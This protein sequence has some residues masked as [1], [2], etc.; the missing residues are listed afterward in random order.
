MN[1]ALTARQTQILKSI[2]DEYLETAEPVGSASLEKKYSLGISP[3]TI[4][5]EMANLTSMGYL[6]QPHTSAGRIPTSVAMKFYI[7][8][9]MEEKQMSLADEVKAKEEVWDV[10]GNLDRL[11]EEATKALASRTRNIAITTT[12]DGRVWTAGLANIFDNPEFEDDMNS[13][14]NIFS[15]IDNSPHV[16]ELFFEKMAG[17]NTIEV[18]FGEDLGWRNLSPI[19]IVA[20]QFRIGD[21]RGAMGIVGPVRQQ[22]PRV[23]PV[24]RKF[25]EM[26]EELIA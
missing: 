11:L 8:Q 4:R 7:S 22:F 1:Q 2:I 9:L 12:D 6:K 14:M 25:H 17:V 20:T 15:L 5:N 18:I 24:L 26:M 19:S 10:R 16:K 3:A 23:I 21:R 13:C